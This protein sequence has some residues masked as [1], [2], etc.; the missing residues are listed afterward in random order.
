MTKFSIN[1]LGRVLDV[2]GSEPRTLAWPRLRL[3]VSDILAQ[4]EI[5]LFGCQ[6]SPT[7]L[8]RNQGLCRWTVGPMLSDAWVEGLQRL[9]LT[10]LSSLP[11][12]QLFRLVGAGMSR[13][14]SWLRWCITLSLRTFG[15][16]HVHASK[17]T[18][19]RSH[20]LFGCVSCHGCATLRMWLP[21]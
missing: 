18:A 9:A 3:V 13:G 8:T 2:L 15:L 4:A 1:N 20:T 5:L 17:C 6:V 12:C 16:R 10:P 11:S 21:S 7:L 19:V 14:L